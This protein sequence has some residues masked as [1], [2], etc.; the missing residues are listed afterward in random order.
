M[1]VYLKNL[2]TN[3]IIS[4]YDNVIHWGYNFVE[5]NNGGRCKI[6][7]N[8]ETEYFTDIE[9]DVIEDAIEERN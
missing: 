5:F 8:T 1:K 7:C 3:E 4:E 2:E 6:Y 9:S